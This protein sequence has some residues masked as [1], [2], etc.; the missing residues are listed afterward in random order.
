MYEFCA[1]LSVST[2]QCTTYFACE[3]FQLYSII[4]G[5]VTKDFLAPYLML[6]L[7]KD[8]WVFFFFSNLR[9]WILGVVM[10]V[11]FWGRLF[12]NSWQVKPCFISECLPVVQLGTMECVLRNTLLVICMFALF[13]VATITC[14]LFEMNTFPRFIPPNFLIASYVLQVPLISALHFFKVVNSAN[15]PLSCRISYFCVSLVVSDDRIM[16]D[17]FYD[18]HPQAER[19]EWG[20]VI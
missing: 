1:V 5:H 19:G 7:L 6:L 15:F 12:V 17:Q 8:N 11:L 2:G 9:I 16:R 3:N 10:V 13:A 20:A 14:L 4:V 18:G